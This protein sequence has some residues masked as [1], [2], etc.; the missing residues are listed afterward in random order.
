MQPH[1]FFNCS[2]AI[3]VPPNPCQLEAKDSD[4]KDNGQA[5]PSPSGLIA[6]LWWEIA[7]NSK[8]TCWLS[9]HESGI[10]VLAVCLCRTNIYSIRY[11]KPLL[12][13]IYEYPRI[14][15]WSTSI[16]VIWFLFLC[17]N[18]VFFTPWVCSSVPLE[19]C[20][21]DKPL[22]CNDLHTLMV[23]VFIKYCWSVWLIK[24]NT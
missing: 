10:I 6:K 20:K 8:P 17:E 3:D 16:C 23:F 14:V 7:A 24:Y 22:M 21:I 19:I 11:G 4:T 18:V 9:L 12:W 15:M 5:K 2:P 1:G 13:Y